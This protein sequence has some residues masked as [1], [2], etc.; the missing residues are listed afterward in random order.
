MPEK[1]LL[2]F[3]E[4]SVAPRVKKPTGFGSANYHFPDFNIQK[5][6]LTQQ[7]KSM[8]QSFIT[9]ES[10]GLQPEY[11]LVIEVIDSVDDFHRAVRA[12]ANLEWLAE[13]DEENIEPDGNFYRECNIGKRLFYEKIEEINTK[14]SSKIWNSLK[15]NNFIDKDGLIQ[16]SSNLSD[17][18]EFIPSDFQQYNDK[19]LKA[20]KD[21][22][23]ESKNKGISGHLYL[24]MSNKQA[25]D[26][27]L[28]LWNQWD[29]ADRNLPRGYAQWAKIFKQVKT[30]RKW[31]IQ[32]RLRDTGIIDYWKEEIKD[33]NGTASK[34]LFEIEL[35]YRND[36]TKRA[37]AENKIKEL[38]K[39]ENGDIVTTCAINEIRFHAI[40]AKLP[41]DSIEKVIK[42]NY[43]SIF[44][45]DEVMFFKP[46]G[47]CRVDGYPDGEERVFESGEVEGE[48][49][50][51]IFDGAPFAN[52]TLLQNRLII[53]DPDDFESSYQVN[54]RKHGTAMA[55][56]VC[57]GELD[58]NGQSL[59]RP[60][61]FR[62]IMKPDRDDFL[63]STKREIIPKDYFFEDIIERSVRRLFE[64]ENGES[65]VAPTIKIINLSI[66]DS[67]KMFFNQLSSTARVLDWL[68]YKYNIL[69]CV[70]SGNINST[71]DLGRTPTEVN[72]L[73]DEELVSLTVRVIHSDIR[74]RKILSP[75]ESINS[76]TVGAIHTDSSTITAMGNRID[77]L[78][79]ENMPSPITAHGL[80]RKNS[81]KP[82][83]YIAGGRQLFDSSSNKYSI[84]QSIEAP[85]QLVATT[86][87]NLGEINRSVYTR[88]T[89]NAT[90][91]A[92]RFASQI[93]EMLNDLIS[94][95]NANID[96]NSIAAILKA[97]LVHG[98]SWNESVS[99][100]EAQ[101]KTSD[102]SRQFKKILARYLGYG[103]PDINRVL[104]CTAQRATAIGYGVIKKDEKH[105]FRFPIPPSLSGNNLKRRLT[106]TLAWFSP[107]NTENKNYRKANL[108]VELNNKIGTDRINADWQQ[109]KNGTVQH[110]VLEGKDVIA[111]QEGDYIQISVIC[112]E[113]AG[114]LDDEIA[115][116]LAIT[117]ETAEGTDI[118]IYDEIKERISIPITVDEQV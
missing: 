36:E 103:I 88:G 7:F 99:I 56:L 23:A 4:P 80:G 24:S 68:A 86:P 42:N 95:N 59:N 72:S 29:T 93:Y 62:P 70:S 105:D 104:E 27:L 46:V 65:P 11:V 71:I 74:N 52:H 82:E 40:K 69:F 101:L 55:S 41:A 102:N 34:I 20:I 60:V 84:S 21:I 8:Q 22:V 33:K 44:S 98:A 109:V 18:I 112:R 111:I 58:G 83:I 110:E 25:I 94:E 108:S 78:P 53:D 114:T 107:I 117:L 63:H 79:N 81:V 113:D 64:G 30:I 14:Q 6:R 49:V 15:K 39:S 106:L 85:G 32:D 45:S 54:E 76:I 91:L 37:E 87:V 10:A 47:Q 116:G 66:G 5:D 75:A 48:P 9:D 57:H 3:P 77:I 90:A 43:T 26:K 89:S 16:N 17:C 92:T 118:P 67:S 12:I 61:Y 73:S 100:Y 35:W 28:S 31:D 51:A 19:I 1:P 38:I 96:N 50:V 13:I 2:I 97:L 115:F